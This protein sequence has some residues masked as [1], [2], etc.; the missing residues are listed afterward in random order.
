VSNNT[1]INIP[2]VVFV[3]STSSTAVSIGSKAQVSAW[4]S[5]VP[6][7]D[8]LAGMTGPSVTDST[9]NPLPNYGSFVIGGN[10]KTSYTINPGI[11]SQINVSGSAIVT[12]NAGVYIIEGGGL[13][14]SGGA[15]VTGTGVMIYNAGS[16]YPNSGGNFG[17]FT[18]SGNGTFNLSAA[19][20]GPYAGILIFQSRQNTRA[21]SISGSILTSM[22]G[23]IYA[24]SALLS[25]S[26][27][28]QLQSLL[29]V[30]MLNV[31][32]GAA[33]TQI[34]AG[35]DGTGDASGIANTLLAGNLSLYINDPSGLFTS[36]QLARIQDAINAWDA[37]LDPY[38]VTITEV[39]DPT[40][41]NFVIDTGST[42]ACGGAANGVLGCFN[43]PNAEIT[44]LQG[45]NWYAGSDPSQIGANQYDFETTVLHELGH[46]L[47][48]G[49]STNPSSPMYEILAA[50]VAD[51]TVTVADLNIPDP[52]AGADPQMAAGFHLGTTAMATAQN[53]VA[54]VAG[55]GGSASGPLS[56]LPGPLTVGGDSSPAVAGQ[57]A[58]A[59]S[60][61]S[62][63]NSQAITGVGSQVSVAFQAIDQ[64]SEQRL[65]P[66]VN[67]ESTEF[68]PA[69]D[70]A[71][72]DGAASGHEQP[73]LDT[74]PDPAHPVIFKRDRIDSEDDPNSTP[75]GPTIPGQ[76]TTDSALS[77]LAI[78]MV[79]LYGRNAARLLAHPVLL[80]G[81]AVITEDG[82]AATKSER[83]EFQ[84]VPVLTDQMAQEK[85][86]PRSAPFAARLAAILLLA[87][88]SGRPI[89][90]KN[91]KT[92]RN[93]HYWNKEAR[94]KKE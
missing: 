17:G 45:W 90:S 71:G 84:G 31:S 15:S 20:S 39:S 74:S 30:G 16:N 94:S 25:L 36:D 50:G 52:P 9:G 58:A 86:A 66:W 85:R 1:S 22:N 89:A 46:A 69:L 55:T 83:G 6:V 77:D 3:D 43:A 88:L 24:R 65:I 91:R 72:R 12:M 27:G 34:A 75:I 93:D 35:T 87:N 56:V 81:N 4:A 61:Q 79:L 29:D 48:L 63:V 82:Q 8:P 54:V 28:A 64:D 53:G 76:R 11:Y 49:G 38:S 57:G 18:L 41:A 10:T 42:S 5:G 80:A 2:G 40:Q 78:E 68:V 92:F 21:L 51:R 59:S 23:T 62:I 47:G 19:T 44:M 37:I 73:A 33:L 60:Q 7:P 32:G 13:A 70:S 67:A 26:G 14:A